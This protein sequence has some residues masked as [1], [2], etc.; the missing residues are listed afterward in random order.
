M[1]IPLGT[2]MVEA[3]SW[4]CVGSASSGGSCCEDIWM[5]KGAILLPF[6]K[7]QNRH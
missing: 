4:L 3:R 2:D 7:T 5:R 1:D 6:Y